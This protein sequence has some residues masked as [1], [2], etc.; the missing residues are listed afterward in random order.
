VLYFT[1]LTGGY[2]FW[3]AFSNDPLDIRW[4][5]ANTLYFVPTLFI[6]AWVTCWSIGRVGISSLIIVRAAMV[7]AIYLMPN[8][9]TLGVIGL[10][11]FA[12]VGWLLAWLNREER[13]IGWIDG[14]AIRVAARR[15]REVFIAKTMSYSVYCLL[16]LVVGALHGNAVASSYVTG[17]RLK[18]LYA[19]LFQPLIQT[20]YLWQ[21][22]SSGNVLHKQLVIWMLNIGNL[23]VFAGIMVGIHAGLLPLLGDRFAEVADITF[24]AVAAGF[25]VSTASLLYLHIF[26]LGDYSVF[27]RAAIAQMVTFALLFSVM[28]FFPG[29]KPAW[30]L[31]TGEVLLF[32]AVLGQILFRRDRSTAI[33]FSCI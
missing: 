23:A 28:T 4:V 5:T 30:V 26:P 6:P 1:S 19:T 16:P 33:R 20:V 9:L 24:Y 2:F 3:N 18:A 27:N 14:A 29:L 22:Q 11:F 25:S 32:V 17:E 10:V 7:V 31:C 8:A 13:V 12:F 15:V 21:F